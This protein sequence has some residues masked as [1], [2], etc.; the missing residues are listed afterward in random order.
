MKK[1]SKP[2]LSSKLSA[3]SSKDLLEERREKAQ[4]RYPFHEI[5]PHLDIK[6]SPRARRMALRVETKN[7]TVELV[8]PKRASIRSAYEFAL[9][10]A[11]WIQQSIDELPKPIEF[12]HGTELPVLGKKRIIDISYD[13]SAKVTDIEMTDDIIRVITNKKEAGSRIRRYLI[14]VAKKELTSMAHEKAERIDKDIKK[15]DVKDTTSRW[16]SCSHDGKL[17]FSWR[18]IF[19]PSDAMDYVV[20]H[21]V[22]HL[23]HLDH[24]PAF[25]KV[26]EALSERYTKG[27]RWMRDNGGDLMRYGG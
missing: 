3:P 17:S 9:K 24:S 1:A 21:E 18:L 22:A 2:L 20:A 7:R 4:N 8:I 6:I 26:C 19:A 27:K 12:T 25:W 5:S 16:G 23:S 14:D 10:N 11:E 15:I 13:P